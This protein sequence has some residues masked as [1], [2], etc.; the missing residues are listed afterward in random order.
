MLSSLLL[1][2]AVLGE[3]PI[4]LAILEVLAV[5]CLGVGSILMRRLFIALAGR[6]CRRTVGLSSF[7][8]LSSS[9]S[10]AKIRDIAFGVL[11]EGCDDEPGVPRKGAFPLA[12]VEGA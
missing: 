5:R 9:I 10:S 1:L 6:D 2:R 4:R 11:R 8:V 3:P 12:G 7:T